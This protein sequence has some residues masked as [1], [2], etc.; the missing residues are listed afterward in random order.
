M[1]KLSSD[2]LANF[3]SIGALLETFKGWIN[4][5]R[6]RIGNT[7]D[8][9]DVL[10]ATP[11]GGGITLP[12][13]A[14]DVDYDNATS[15][16]TATDVQAA[17]DELAALPTGSAFPHQFDDSK[18]FRA[19]LRLS[20]DGLVLTNESA[21][22]IYSTA[23][24]YPCRHEDSKVY[25]EVNVTGSA[26]TGD[27]VGI[28]TNSAV[29][30]AADSVRSDADY[31][32]H[33]VFKN[34]SF[35]SRSTSGTGSGAWGTA[36]GADPV[37]GIA[38]DRTSGKIYYAINGTWQESEEPDSD[39]STIQLTVWEHR[40]R[41]YCSCYTSGM[42]MEIVARKA[43]MTYSVPTGYVALAG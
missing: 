32:Y 21:S 36:W 12:I 17:I 24:S 23:V 31:Y 28:V 39:N 29:E 3:R 11:S 6:L 14:T 27:F 30:S 18:T 35:T 34:G 37:I 16:L 26:N 1:F 7:E 5:L 38:V 4:D 40:F 43:D 9:L 19:P 33:L 13:D 10:E 20:A 8:R 2:H 42:S 22:D 41:A 15:G 25:F